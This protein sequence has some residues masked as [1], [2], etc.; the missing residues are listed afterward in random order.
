LDLKPKS[1]RVRLDGQLY[2]PGTT[3]LEV[4]ADGSSRGLEI[5]APGYQPMM[6]WFLAD[7][8]QSISALLEPEPPAPEKVVEKGQR[9]RWTPPVRKPQE[10]APPKKATAG[11]KGIDIPIR[12][13]PY[14]D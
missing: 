14:D 6:Q 11:K 12:K 13:S 3:V 8:H 9:K 4:E 7:K 10:A 2:P 1:A 5:F